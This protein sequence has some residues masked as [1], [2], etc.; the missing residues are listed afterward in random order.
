MSTY[1]TAC[2]DKIFDHEV[3][4][5]FDEPYCSDC[6]NERFDYCS[7]CDNVIMRTDANYNSEGTA[8]C[9]NCWESEF[10]DA[11]PN[12]PEVYDEDRK[13]ILSLSR[14]FLE[15][16]VETRRLI[17]VNKKDLLLGPIRSKIGLV[18][19]PI[20]LF[21]LK[22]REE[23]QISASANILE[24]VKEFALLNFTDCQ[25][26]EGLGSSRLGLSLSLR[27]NHQAELIN[28]I[29]NITCIRATVPA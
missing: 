20:H 8:Y 25:I 1:C 18:H 14:A 23:Y 11:C 19:N 6:F 29:K 2:N 21:G 7:S 15:G 4:Y 12:N 26:I 24:D 3:C 16:K 22:D 9:D 13:L 10:D 27:Q 5:A 28:L 17:S